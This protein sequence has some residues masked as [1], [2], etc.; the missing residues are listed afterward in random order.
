MTDIFVSSGVDSGLVIDI[1]TALYVQSG[2]TVVDTTILAGGEIII[3]DGGVASTTLIGPGGSASVTSGGSA[4]G[5]TVESAASFVISAGGTDMSSYVS[6]GGTMLAGGSVNTGIT[7]ASGAIVSRDVFVSSGEVLSGVA[8]SAGEILEVFS[9]GT[10]IS[11]EIQSGGYT[12]VGSGGVLSAALIEAQGNVSVSGGTAIATEVSAGTL[13]ISGGV[14]ISTTVA[15]GGAFFLSNSVNSATVA[16]SGALI[17][18]DSSLSSGQSLSG[19]TISASETLDVSSG[20]SAVDV[21]VASRGDITVSSGGIETGTTI[22][23][24]GYDNA[25]GTSEDTVIAGTLWMFSPEFLP[26]PVLDGATIVGGGTVRANPNDVVSDITIAGSGF[27][28]DFGFL[29]GSVTFEDQGRLALYSNTISAT[30]SGFGD[31]NSIDLLQLSY[32]PGGFAVAETG[33]LVIEE[34]GQTTVIPLAGDYAG[35]SFSL[36]G[37]DSLGGTVITVSNVPCFVT[38]TLIETAEGKKPV[39]ALAAGD[40]VST[41]GGG[42]A[43]VIWLGRRTV[44]CRRHPEPEQI[45]PIVIAA[46]AFADG[47]PSRPLLLS[48]DHAIWAE[49]VLIPVKHLLNGLSIRQLAADTVTYVH[50]EL[51]QHDVIFAEGLPVESYLDSGDRGAFTDASKPVT[52]HPVFGR[53]RPDVVLASEALAYAPLRV[54]GPE[55]ERLRAHLAARAALLSRRKAV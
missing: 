2:G 36:A 45:R 18:I 47:L 11:A 7:S 29:S 20:A 28:N 5:T 50:V 53:D 33:K 34:G 12:Y 27:L 30:I 41:L 39:E 9:G 19:A 24:G 22:A 21:T 35:A 46:H 48:P 25:Y 4:S 14:A 31:G 26:D 16:E 52:L 40:L 44:D 6:S 13:S 38:G 23:A 54:T 17:S 55:V 1:G 42:T 8:I 43:P 37:D 10:V 15:S 3:A 32:A 51:P 49:G